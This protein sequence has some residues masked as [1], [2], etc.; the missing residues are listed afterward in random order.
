MSLMNSQAASCPLCGSEAALP[1]LQVLSRRVVRCRG[2]NLVYRNSRPTAS[3]LAGAFSREGA[4]PELEERV[5]ERRSRHFRRFLKI[6]GRP[7]RLLDVGC[8]YGFFLRL[9]QEAGSDAIGVDLD[10]QAVE[11]AR[12]RLQVNAL[13]GDL[14]DFRFPDGSFDLVTLWN[15]LECVPDPLDLLTEVHRVLKVG[16]Q[17]FIRTQNS[18]WHRLSYSLT[19]LVRRLGVK[20]IFEK[21]PYLTFIFNLNSFSRSTLRLLVERAG[22]TSL[23]V[24]NSR[25]VTGDP[26]LGV[27]PRGELLLSLAK[28]AVHGLAQGLSV[29][30]GD[31]WLIGPSL[32]AWGRRVV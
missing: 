3:G 12:A 23:R 5:G 25:P 11:Y 26:Y 8:G 19:G 31:R 1:L 9:A 14:R 27:G 16:G 6:A 32:E 18:Q 30:S 4:N 20:A 2:C 22:F 17:V 13:S 10:P 28:L 7:G 15:V 24:R 29:V 21:H